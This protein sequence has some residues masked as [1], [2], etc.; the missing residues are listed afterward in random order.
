M[1]KR[2]NLL[3]IIFVL[4]LASYNNYSK[5]KE[6]NAGQKE[7]SCSAACMLKSKTG[8]IN[9]KLT[10]PEQQKRKNTVIENLKKQTLEKKRISR[11]LCL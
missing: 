4:V 3:V 10:T 6:T 11:W 5:H 2:F 9:C 8:E 7:S 1:I